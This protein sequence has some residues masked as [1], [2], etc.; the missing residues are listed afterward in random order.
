MMFYSAD[1]QRDAARPQHA[2]DNIPN[3]GMYTPVIHLGD[4]LDILPTIPDNSVHLIIGDLPYGTTE[5]K[6]DSLIDLATMWKEI[7]RILTVNGTAVMFASQPF[8]TTLSASNLKQLRYSLV[9]EK[10]RVTGF[11]HARNRVLKAHEDILIFS[12]GTAVHAHQSTNRMI[13]NPQGVIERGIQKVKGNRKTIKYMR[14]GRAA[15]A[16]GK[17][18]RAAT[19]YP[20]SVLR[21]SKDE[22][23][24]H[25]T[26][27][28]VALLEY[29]IRT[30]SNEGDTILD[31]TMGSGSTLVAARN[32]SRQSIGIEITTGFYEV[33]RTRLFGEQKEAA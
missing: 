16:E 20:R 27:K 32:T 19:N 25:P 8:T 7:D 6:W 30:Y 28:P 17:E 2:N 11:L 22:D 1:W 26:A 4:C 23:H 13:Y 29:L 18:Y 14:D 12:K 15:H 33:A 21:F 3:Y 10:N 9:W 24:L 5:S 31:P